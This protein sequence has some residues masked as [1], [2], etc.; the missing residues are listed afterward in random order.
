METKKRHKP[1]KSQPAFEAAFAKQ[2]R[3][4]GRLIVKAKQKPSERVI[5]DLRVALRRCRSIADGAAA[6]DP[7]PAWPKIKK[8]GKPLFK[9]L[10]ELR[11]IQ[12]MRGWLKRLAHRGNPV[13]RALDERLERREKKQLRRTFEAL[14]QFDQVRW[15]NWS[16]P[17][18]QRLGLLAGMPETFKTIARKRLEEVISLHY[19]A[20]RTLSPLSFH[21]LRIAVKRFRYTIENFHPHLHKVWGGELAELQDLLGELHDLDVVLE[22]LAETGPVFGPME[23]GRWERMIAAEREARIAAYQGKMCGKEPLWKVWRA[24]L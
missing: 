8:Q 11:D 6:V 19:R 16:K 15:K 23:R 5:H 2:M 21:R 20:M 24:G 3:S 7:G 12:V 14:R 4:V 1:S 9:R 18:S 10:G 13:R 17:L 22:S